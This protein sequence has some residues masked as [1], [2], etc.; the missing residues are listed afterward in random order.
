MVEITGLGGLVILILDLWA[1]ISIIGSAATTG[2]KVLWCLAVILLPILGFIAWLI[3][4]PRADGR[5][6]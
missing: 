5:R 1:I 2:K 3:F 4:G 6:T